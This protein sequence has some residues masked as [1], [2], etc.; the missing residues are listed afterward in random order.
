MAEI[1]RSCFDSCLIGDGYRHV[2]SRAEY[3]IGI[4]WEKVREELITYIANGPGIGGEELG[5]GNHLQQIK[6]IEE[7][8]PRNK[9]QMYH[10]NQ[11]YK[12]WNA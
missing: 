11:G 9:D 7:K 12:Q 6:L 10:G 3:W 4:E 1:F 2:E 5:I 8:G